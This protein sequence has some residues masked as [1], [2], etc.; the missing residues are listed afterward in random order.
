MPQAIS[1]A[2]LAK[3]RS[4]LLEEGRDEGT[5]ELYV[6]NVRTCSRE[7]FLTSRLTDSELASK[8]LHTNKAALS[9]WA[10]FIGD[11]D[12]GKR[13]KRIKLPPSV[14][15][16]PKQGLEQ[17]DW[18]RLLATVRTTKMD[19]PIRAV[20]LIMARRGFRVADGLRLQKEEVTAALRTG[21]LST[22]GKGRKRREIDA[23][24]IREALE[25]LV[26]EKRAWKRVED[27]IAHTLR[28]GRLRRKA[29]A[30]RV[31][32]ALRRCAKKAGITGVHPHRL[33][34]TYA[35]GF[36]RLFHGDPQALVKLQRHMGWSDMETALSYVD[37]V[38]MADLDKKGADMIRVLDE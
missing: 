24:P 8:T 2:S 13:L 4:H 3:F 6:K 5:A 38:N 15:A 11:A 20:I 23:A 14:R 21:I 37:E 28:T 26:A 10:N 31:A 1:E 7:R 30:Q 22:E 36:L 18:K 35:L 33:R 12:L 19:E 27:L 34:R 25:I 32:V 9:S 16:K 29:A 17:A